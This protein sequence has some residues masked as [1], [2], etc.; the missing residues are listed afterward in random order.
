MEFSPT[1]DGQQ[2]SKP[3]PPRFPIRTVFRYRESGASLWRR[4]MTIDISRSGVLFCAEYGLPPKT[5]LEMQIAFP[6]EM[7]GNVG[8]RILCCGPVVRS[9][10]GT[11][12]SAQPCIAAAFFNYR[13]AHI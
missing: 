9:M 7:T 4:G 12:A 2:N 6:P 8:A 13:F 10:P 3:R 1:G 11:Q 5:V